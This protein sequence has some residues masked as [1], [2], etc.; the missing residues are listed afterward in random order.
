MRGVFIDRPNIPQ[1]AETWDV[2]I[3]LSFIRSMGDN[4]VLSLFNLASKLVMLLALVTRQRAQTLSYFDLDNMHVY[5]GRVVF[6]VRIL[7]KQSRPSY[8]L[9]PVTILAFSD[10]MPC[11]VSCLNVYILKTKQFR[12]IE[13][14]KLILTTQKPYREASKDNISRWIRTLLSKAGFD[15]SKFSGHITRAAARAAARSAG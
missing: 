13:N 4:E 15:T 7:A 12:S 5:E 14:R 11:V 9:K 1:Y 8:H 3:V 6:C 2:S 10:K